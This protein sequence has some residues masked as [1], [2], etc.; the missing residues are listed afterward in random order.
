MTRYMFGKI[1]FVVKWKK[2]RCQIGQWVC[3]GA[4]GSI[5]E[6]RWRTDWTGAVGLEGKASGA[7][8]E[9]ESNTKL[10]RVSGGFWGLVP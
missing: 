3:S 10:R 1:A 8:L 6:E 9:T 4:L 5:Q 2:E 7:E